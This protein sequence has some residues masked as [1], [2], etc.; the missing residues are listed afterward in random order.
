LGS[1]IVA[2]ASGSTRMLAEARVRRESSLRITVTHL[3]DGKR[4]VFRQTFVPVVS[5]SCR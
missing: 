5:D 2:S 4:R 3:W 1:G